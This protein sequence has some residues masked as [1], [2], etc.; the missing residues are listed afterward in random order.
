MLVC[1]LFV[2]VFGRQRLFTR[3]PGDHII[4][5]V[6]RVMIA[7]EHGPPITFVR[8]LARY[9]QDKSRLVGDDVVA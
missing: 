5:D 7:V 6:V 4:E 3:G 1:D 9:L 2:C 8:E